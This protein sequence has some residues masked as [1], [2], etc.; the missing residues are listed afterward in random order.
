MF[1]NTL[2]TPPSLEASFPLNG[3]KMAV[4]VGAPKPY[5]LPTK[6][7]WAGFQKSH[8]LGFQRPAL[9]GNDPAS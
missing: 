1:W 3:S 8:E 6:W 9:V 7:V 5:F 2:H 4:K